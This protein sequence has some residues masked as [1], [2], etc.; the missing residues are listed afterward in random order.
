MSSNILCLQ[1]FDVKDALV[2]DWL[3]EP[4]KPTYILVRFFGTYDMSVYELMLQ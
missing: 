3:Q 2:P 4:P 1:V